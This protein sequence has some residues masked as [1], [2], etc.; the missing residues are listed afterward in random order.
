MTELR[1]VT[2][3]T[4][5]EEEVLLEA[6]LTPGGY[7][8]QC[9]HKPKPITNYDSGELVF[10]DPQQEYGLF[11]TE[12]QA[13]HVVNQFGEDMFVSFDPKV[14]EI[15]RVCEAARRQEEVDKRYWET[16][17]FKRIADNLADKYAKLE[18][19]HV[20]LNFMLEG[21]QHQR[22]QFVDAPLWRR[23]WIALFPAKLL[24]SLPIE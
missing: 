15:F 11:Y 6:P 10:G 5:S 8:M 17:D 9:N 3:Y 21:I 12:M 22:R 4:V 7:W 14:E 24:Y 23:L 2:L 19:R 20:G 16:R 13:H 1:R 18:V